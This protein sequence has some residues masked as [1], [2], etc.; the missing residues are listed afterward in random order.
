MS[1]SYLTFHWQGTEVKVF[2]DPIE[3]RGLGPMAAVDITPQAVGAD[4][5]SV[6]APLADLVLLGHAAQG[7]LDSRRATRGVDT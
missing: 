5:I 7:V 3:R 1:Q 6:E 4:S 2:L